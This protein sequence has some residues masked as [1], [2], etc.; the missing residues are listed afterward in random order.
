MNN[1]KYDRYGFKTDITLNDYVKSVYL[2]N[3]YLNKLSANWK[4]VTDFIKI[5]YSESDKTTYISLELTNGE[6]VK[7]SLYFIDQRI[8]WM[9]CDHLDIE[10]WLKFTGSKK[11]LPRPLYIAYTGNYKARLLQYVDRDGVLRRCNIDK[12]QQLVSLYKQE[13][14]L[15][16][17]TSTSTSQKH[18]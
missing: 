3:T 16:K 17:C 6:T 13:K 2:K 4:P 7:K 14:R 10:S 8:N 9:P 12:A 5:E 1:A 18:H 11:V 15:L